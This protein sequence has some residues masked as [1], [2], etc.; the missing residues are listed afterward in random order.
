MKINFKHYL[1]E[2]P[3]K[4][5]LLLVVGIFIGL[6]IGAYYGS[7]VA[8]IPTVESQSYQYG[9]TDAL[10]Q[11]GLAKWTPWI[12]GLSTVDDVRFTSINGDRIN[13]LRIERR[14]S[15]GVMFLLATSNTTMVQMYWGSTQIDENTYWSYFRELD[16]NTSF[17][18]DIKSEDKH[19]S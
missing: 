14:S 17:R 5:F 10:Q 15:G 7:W 12:Y 19:D 8:D 3:P 2:E 16:L 1:Q 4:W 13:I 9:Y 11:Y 6:L 18:I